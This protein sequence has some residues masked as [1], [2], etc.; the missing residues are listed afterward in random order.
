MRVSLITMT[1]SQVCRP[2]LNLLADFSRDLE[3]DK[4]GDGEIPKSTSPVSFNEGSQ[5]QGSDV[6][7]KGKGYAVNACSES[8]M[9]RGFS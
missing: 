9:S 8:K 2:T 6:S 1:I 4:V 7:Q 5:N 3:Y